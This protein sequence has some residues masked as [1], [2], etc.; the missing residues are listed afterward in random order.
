M[1]MSFLVAAVE[2]FDR[3]AYP[4]DTGAVV[5][6]VPIQHN[7][8][9]GDL[10]MVS[11]CSKRLCVII[12]SLLIC[13]AAFSQPA[14]A[15]Q[16]LLLWPQGA[17]QAKGDQ[18][19]DKPSLIVYLPENAKAPTAAVVI[20]PGGGYGG[21][22]ISHEGHNVAK[23]LNSVGVAGIIL[24][25]RLPGN[26]YR[27]PIPLTDAQRAL[28]LVRSKASQWNID[29]NRIGVMGFSA[30]GHLAS[31]LGTHFHTGKK[32][33]PDPIDR[34]SC[35]PDFM[36]LVYPVVTMGPSAHK[37]SKKNLL[38]PDPN[39]TLVRELS[40]ELQVNAE[41]PMAFLVHAN[42]DRTVAT[43]DSINFYLAM[44]KAGVLV[45]LHLYEKGGHGFGIGKSQSLAGTTWHLRL[46]EWL[47]EHGIIEK[48]HEK[49]RSAVS[50]GESK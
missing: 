45:E 38:G 3:I 9:K 28:S 18:D 8:G 20:C 33:A 13:S 4:D 11:G 35:R 23:W 14:S 12:L 6:M 37:G 22:A 21:L 29:P 24:K 47:G 25:Y 44:R 48:D 36:V 10:N 1:G 34:V 5:V 32:D 27:H 40:N 49:H 42:D 31:T 39:E 41:T 19:Q 16:T 26:G 43:E 46:A 7:L 2:T 30:G 15:P 50:A 17:P